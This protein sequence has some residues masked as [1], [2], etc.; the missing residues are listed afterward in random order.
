MSILVRHAMTER[1]TTGRP[2]MTAT[3]AAELMRARDVGAIPV[4]EGETLVGVVTDRDLVIR[5]L[6]EGSD[7]ARVRLGD[8]ATPAVVTVSPDMQ[9]SEARDLMAELQVRR[10][11]VMK[12]DALVG[13]LSL[14]D[15]ALA[16]ASKRAV[17]QTLEEISESDSTAELHQEPARGTPARRRERSE[18]RSTGRVGLTEKEDNA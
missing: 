15:V 11:P 3:E 2:E 14:G 13:I 7:P 12:G 1:P 8:I 9:L 6:A 16:D 5:V 18:V 4:V 17:G 10:L